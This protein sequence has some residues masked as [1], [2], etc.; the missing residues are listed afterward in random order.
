MFADLVVLPLPPAATY[1][2]RG[3]NYFDV[4]P[5]YGDGEAE[6]KMGIALEPYRKR[7]FLACKTLVRDVGTKI[8]VEPILGLPIIKDLIVDMEPFFNN[9]KRIKPWFINNDPEPEKERYQTPERRLLFDDTTKCILCAC[10]T[11]S[12]PSES[13]IRVFSSL[14]ASSRGRR[15]GS[16]HCPAGRSRSKSCRRC[17]A[18]LCSSSIC[19]RRIR[20]CLSLSTTCRRANR[21]RSRSV[22]VE[23]RFGT[24]EI[25]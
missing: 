8:K 3:I 16:T 21:A 24:R 20:L 13:W 2:D 4:A 23:M 11:T 10:C 6:E 5:F 18:S 19:P 12:C 25:Q 17:A 22:A 7:V 15:A 9:Y 1:F 14:T